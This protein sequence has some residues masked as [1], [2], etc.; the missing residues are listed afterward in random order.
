MPSQT[1]T[2]ITRAQHE[3]SV[4]AIRRGLSAT[5]TVKKPLTCSQWAEEYFYLSPESSG[6][7]GR[8]SAIP[9]QTAMLDVMGADWPRTVDVIKSARVGYTKI[10][11]AVCAYNLEHKR[12]NV[13]AYQPTDSDAKSFC[14]TEIDPM[15]RDVPVL[16]ELAEASENKKRSDT[17]TQKAVGNKIFNIL[18]GK[19][20]ARFRRV[21]SDLVMYDELDGFDREIGDEG[22]PLSLGDRCIT[23]SSY[24]KSIRGSTPR[25]SHDSLID[26]QVKLAR[27][28]FRYHVVC[29]NCEHA[30][31]FVWAGFKWADDA[32]LDVEA[33]ADTAYYECQGCDDHWHYSELWPLLESGFW[34]TIEESEDGEP[35]PGYRIKTGD[36]DPILL[37]AEGLTVDWP[38]HVAF[39]IWAAYSVF[40]S[41]QDLVLEWLQA[42]GNVLKLKTFVNHRLGEPFEE[43]GESLDQ[44]D[45][46]E[47]REHFNCPTQ[48]LAVAASIDVQINRVEVS[49][50][51]FGRSEESWLLE[52]TPIYG[53]PT[54]I[55][56]ALWNDLDDHLLGW[57]I[58]RDDGYTLRIDAVAVDTG[59]QTDNCYQ[60][61]ATS[62]H[63][64]I[65][66]IKGLPGDRAIVTAPTRQRTSKGQ[67][68]DLFGVGV[69]N[70]KALVMQRL[71]SRSR[72][73][74]HL[75]M[76]TTLEQCE[77]FTAEK[78]ITKYTRGFAKKVWTK[79]RDRNEQLDL[80]AYAIAALYI[81]KPA[82]DALEVNRAPLD[83]SGQAAPTKQPTP[84]DAFEAEQK[85]AR[86]ESRSSRRKKGYVNRW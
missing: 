85:K 8:W 48:V 83:D 1:S 49:V 11:I 84:G 26:A 42:Q 73:P 65:H 70:A 45:L 28:L 54:T 7:E 15:F 79:L 13:T 86:R 36:G 18:G 52:T 22:D 23:N 31:P 3:A 9:Y 61:I 24:P 82:W 20:P 44:H 51:G 33:R 75:S 46:F 72:S 37:D 30:Q 76:S 38:R 41:W 16:L 64:R 40:M 29:P 78:R 12:R 55:D 74:I 5:L 10:A 67:K 57:N 6:N 69:D 27:M 14:K 66:A 62:R 35:L 77:Q 21:T 63:A 56:S 19:S 39:H 59:Y 53:D 81:L 34:A 25:L 43:V 71:A 4:A 47:R 58:K 32:E 60:Y 2:L 80:A 68:I 17:L 50:Y